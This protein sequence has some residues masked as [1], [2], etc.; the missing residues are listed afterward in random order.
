MIAHPI[1]FSCLPQCYDFSYIDPT[2]LLVIYWFLLCKPRDA[3]GKTNRWDREYQEK[4][5]LRGR[6]DVGRGKV[7]GLR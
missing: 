7:E 3:L 4:W 6:V 1:A 5:G 2:I